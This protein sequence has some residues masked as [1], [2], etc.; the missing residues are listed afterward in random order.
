MI[1]E[2]SPITTTIGI[3]NPH[4]RRDGLRTGTVIVTKMIGHYISITCDRDICI[5]VNI[6]MSKNLITSLIV[7]FSY[8]HILF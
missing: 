7:I 6:I 5:I 8:F 1:L 2:A 4:R 3:D